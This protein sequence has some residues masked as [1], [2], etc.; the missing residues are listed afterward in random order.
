MRRLSIVII[1]NQVHAKYITEDNDGS[2]KSDYSLPPLE[3]EPN[4]MID[5][6]IESPK[7]LQGAPILKMG[8]VR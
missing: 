1:S 8:L 4:E 7:G 2:D 5:D 3:T 6:N